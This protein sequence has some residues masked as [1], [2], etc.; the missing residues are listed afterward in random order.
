MLPYDRQQ[1]ILKILES[2]GHVSIHKLAQLIHV[3]E[4]T[5]RRDLTRMEKQGLIRRTYGGAVLPDQ[6]EYVPISLRKDDNTIAKKKI[7]AQAA[8]LVRK[9]NVIFLDCSSTVQNMI[10]FF[11]ENQEITVITNSISAC[12]Q[13]MN[14][15]IRTYCVGGMVDEKDDALRGKYAE[16][17]IRNVHI[18]LAFFSC[19]SLS[20]D[21][22]L[23]GHHESAVSFLQT[24]LQHSKQRIFLCTHDKVSRTCMHLICTLRDVDAVLCDQPL[25]SELTKMIGKNR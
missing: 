18:D 15:H 9:G 4:P 14:L 10:N 23:G 2:A 6:S 7:A 24:L 13:L 3:S 19:S 5:M 11:T 20:S 16:E 8:Q 22:Q 1:E 21:G 12:Q 17:F 25:P